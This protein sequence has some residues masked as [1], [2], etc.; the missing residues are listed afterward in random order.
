MTYNTILSLSNLITKK[1]KM[2]DLYYYSDCSIGDLY[3]SRTGLYRSTSAYIG[4][5]R[6]TD[7]YIDDIHTDRVG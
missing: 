4:L 1:T 2:Q 3:R 5:Y 7:V 6:S